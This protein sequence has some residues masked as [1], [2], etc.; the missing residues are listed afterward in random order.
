MNYGVIWFSKACVAIGLEIQGLY[1]LCYKVINEKSLVLT[2]G[3][4]V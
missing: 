2:H 1:D 3:Q 4:H